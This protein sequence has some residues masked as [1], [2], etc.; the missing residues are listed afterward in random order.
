MASTHCAWLVKF[1]SINLGEIKFKSQHLGFLR[2]LLKCIHKILIICYTDTNILYTEQ[3]YK[4]L[5]Y[6]LNILLQGFQLIIK[7]GKNLN[8]TPMIQQEP[9]SFIIL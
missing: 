5:F 1:F 2:C 7:L 9:K 3:Y 8:T 6:V 4:G